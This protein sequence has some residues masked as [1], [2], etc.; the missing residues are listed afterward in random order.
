MTEASS[1]P[2]IP[3]PQCGR[4]LHRWPTLDEGGYLLACDE[5]GFEQAVDATAAAPSDPAA[6]HSPPDQRAMHKL[7]SQTN[8]PG[9][10]P[11]ELLEEL[12]AEAR[13]LLESK[14]NT[15]G[16]QVS[17]DLEQRLRG[18]GYFLAEEGQG[19]HLA[20]GGPKPGTGDLSPLD[21]VR[22]AAEL[23]GELP[24]EGERRH[25]PNCQAV[26]P[27]EATHCQWCGH[28][29]SPDPTDSP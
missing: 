25:C 26:L 24:S 17:A 20:G 22:L 10:W 14:G 28:Q 16:K 4:P 2:K 6:D 12:P 7:L 3:C 21:V 9:E 13:Q 18:Y 19:A 5:C 23:E 27:A 8:Q 1:P 11:E 29:L 15:G